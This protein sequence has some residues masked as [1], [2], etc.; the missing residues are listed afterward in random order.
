MYK[1][2][3]FCKIN[4]TTDVTFAMLKQCIKFY[5]TIIAELLNKSSLYNI[6]F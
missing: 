1:L 5:V 4:K 2:S 6:P 3:E